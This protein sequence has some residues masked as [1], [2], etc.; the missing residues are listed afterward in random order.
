MPNSKLRITWNITD[1]RHGG[2]CSDPESDEELNYE[3]T[4]DYPLLSELENVDDEDIPNHTSFN[5][6]TKKNVP[7]S[8]YCKYNGITYSI[9]SANVIKN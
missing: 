6:Y 9:K 5:Y 2:Y 4:Y 3:E 7:H 8:N 1:D